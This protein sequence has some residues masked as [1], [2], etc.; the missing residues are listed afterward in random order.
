MGKEGRGD[1][2]GLKPSAGISLWRKK[3]V[4][5]NRSAPLGVVGGKGTIK[6]RDF[7]G[8][9]IIREA[10][11]SQLF[12]RLLGRF[13]WGGNL[14]HFWGERRSLASLTSTQSLFRK[15]GHFRNKT[16]LLVKRERRG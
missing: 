16:T 10:S 8:E 11:G 14:V 15:G 6:S 12:R 1:R 9:R 13:S 2:K 4:E 5:F 3:I 7:A